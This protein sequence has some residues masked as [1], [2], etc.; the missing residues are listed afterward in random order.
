MTDA[1]F[2]IMA[3]YVLE[4]LQ[5]IVRNESIPIAAAGVAANPRNYGLVL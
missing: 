1:T 3:P 2:K 4:I 5:V